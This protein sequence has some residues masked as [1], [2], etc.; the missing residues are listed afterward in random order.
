MKAVHF[1]AGNIGRGFI[2]ETLADNGFQITF[3]DVN[4]VIIDQ[5]NSGN[6]YTIQLAN[7]AQTKIKVE[8]VNGINNSKDPGEAAAAI[9]TADIVTT[10]I[11]PKILPIIAP[12]IAQGIANRFK[13]GN[14]KKIGVIA[15]ENMIGASQMLKKYVYENLD[16]TVK[17]F[18][19]ENIGFP[20]AAVDRIV[21][22]QKNVDP[23]F[24][25]VDEFKEWVI[26]QSQ[27]KNP[28]LKLKTVH[29]AA[30]L[31]PFIE[32]KLFSVNTGHATVAYTG[33]Y[34]GYSDINSAIADP[35]VLDQLKAVLKETGDLL[36]AKWHFDPEQHKAYQMSIIKRFQN[37][38]LS[39]DIA[40]VG[41]N[42]IR[43]LSY[44]ER[45]IQPIREAK[46]LNL[47]YTALLD[48]VGKIFTFDQA[49]DSESRQLMQMIKDMPIREVIQN[50]TGLS[51]QQL[52][53]QIELSYQNAL[54]AHAASA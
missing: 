41:R 38:H 5:L 14:S 16:P 46:A 13:A 49:E 27:M 11:G 17:K 35:I 40:R 19:D 21:P 29:Y 28:Q 44:N 4:S 32:R 26:D 33:K 20:N 12:L 54:H 24:V 36:I 1:G 37:K 6:S 9:A 31:E 48:T 52:I 2:G 30:D 22:R 8:N 25:T 15:C 23:L 51:D 45:F 3:I 47:K 50:T 43:K 7:D 42:P 10:A 34:E 39:D 18:A 53:D